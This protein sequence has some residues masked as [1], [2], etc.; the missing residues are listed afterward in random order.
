M[1]QQEHRIAPAPS[2]APERGPC[3][4]PIIRA[5]PNVDPKIVMPIDRER[6]DA[7]IRAIEPAVCW[8]K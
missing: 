3:N 4:M 2:S 6:I 5:N 7:K 1:I 8:E